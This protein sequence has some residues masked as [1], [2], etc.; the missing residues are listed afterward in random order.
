[1]NTKEITKL[2]VGS[3]AVYAIIAAC[4]SGGGFNGNDAGK[5]GKGPVP[6]ALADV[7]QSGS[8][9]KAQY[10]AGADGS[11]AYAGMYDTTLKTPCA[12]ATAADGSSRCLPAGAGSIAAT[13]TFSDSSCTQPIYAAPMG[14][15]Q[16]PSFIS[17]VSASCSGAATFHV[18]P[19]GS[20]YTPGANVYVKAGNACNM[21]STTGSTAYFVST[22]SEMPS[23][24]FVQGTLTSE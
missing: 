4:S 11:R 9:L 17:T 8:R 14:C 10:Y 5:D 20:V 2:V 19:K 3:V 1:M 16:A 13:D 23:S 18:Y 12:F 15:T 6:D 24:M 7:S 21:I 22:G